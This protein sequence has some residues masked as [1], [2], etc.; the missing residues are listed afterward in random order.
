MRVVRLKD[1]KA[2]RGNKSRSYQLVGPDSL[3]ARK[4]IITLVEIQAGGSTPLHEHE[5]VESMYYILEGQAEVSTEREKETF[6][7]DTAIYFPA[8]GSH[9]IRNLGRGRLRYMS[10]HAPPYQI[11]DLYKS[12]QERAKLVTTGG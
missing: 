12:W 9:G 3:G 2:L 6:G 4:F 10:C 7:P 11:E 1:A 8:G 5:T